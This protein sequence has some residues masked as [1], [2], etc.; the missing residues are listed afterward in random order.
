MVD[1]EVERMLRQKE[2]YKDEKFYPYYEGK[3]VRNGIQWDTHITTYKFTHDAGTPWEYWSQVWNSIH[4]PINGQVKNFF[5]ALRTMEA[6]YRVEPPDK[7]LTCVVRGSKAAQGGGI[8]HQSLINFWNMRQSPIRLFFY[9][10]FEIPKKIVVGNVEVE[11]ISKYYEKDGSEVDILIDDAFES[12]KGL[13]DLPIRA[14]Y[15]SI[16]GEGDIYFHETEKRT[17]SHMIPSAKSYCPCIVCKE[18]VTLT[19]SY[20]EF[21]FLRDQMTLLGHPPCY[22]MGGRDAYISADI[23]RK[24]EVMR[25]LIISPTVVVSQPIEARSVIAL[26]HE[27]TLEVRSPYVL[28]MKEQYEP[29]PLLYQENNGFGKG[30]LAYDDSEICKMIEGKDVLFRGVPAS[31]LKDTKIGDAKKRN[32]LSTATS[33]EQEVVGFFGSIQQALLGTGASRTIF[34]PGEEREM[35]KVL[36]N[37]SRTGRVWGDFK[38]LVQKVSSRESPLH[39]LYVKGVFSQLLRDWDKVRTEYYV[40][41]SWQIDEKEKKM[42]INDIKEIL[43]FYRRKGYWEVVLWRPEVAIPHFIMAIGKKTKALYRLK[44]IDMYEILR[45]TILDL[46]S[47]SGSSVKGLKVEDFLCFTHTKDWREKRWPEVRDSMMQTMTMYDLVSKK[48]KRKRKESPTG[49]SQ[50]KE[51]CRA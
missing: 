24:G 32:Q 5:V 48:K 45:E 46:R 4:A 10:V 27:M 50:I 22:P 49:K 18:C 21:V 7:K 17:F 25:K 34:V 26:S 6:A 8:W 47:N 31:I 38:E 35:D 41:T 16:K 37:Y 14:Q 29:V 19:G 33:F 2:W 3:K 11:W 40:D 9:D 12:A 15:F 1:N 23:R 28:Q 20:D 51:G 42:S 44:E 43:C 39:G 13:S 36:I 30:A